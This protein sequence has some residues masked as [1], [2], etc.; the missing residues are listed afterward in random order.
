[1]HVCSGLF[2]CRFDVELSDLTGSLDCVVFGEPAQNL[3]RK[4]AVELMEI[5]IQVLYGAD[6]F[7]FFFPF[8]FVFVCVCVCVSEPMFMCLYIHVYCCCVCVVG[9]KGCVG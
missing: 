4:T 2:R 6:V 9:R 5:D 7:S 8:F 3:L 1:M